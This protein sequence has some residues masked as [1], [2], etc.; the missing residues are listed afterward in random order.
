MVAQVEGFEEFIAVR[1]DLAA[2]YA[3]LATCVATFELL[4]LVGPAR[5]GQKLVHTVEEVIGIRASD[6]LVGTDEEVWMASS[7]L[8]LCGVD[9]ARIK[10]VVKTA[11]TVL[12]QLDDSE[13]DDFAGA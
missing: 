5:L 11:D 1:D 10:V 4:D 8:K 2:T 3:R 9:D 7:C 12:C 6:R 13:A